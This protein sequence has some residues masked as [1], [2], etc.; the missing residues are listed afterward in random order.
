MR[1]PQKLKH[2]FLWII[3]RWRWAMA[4]CCNLLAIVQSNRGGLYRI[5]VRWLPILIDIFASFC[6]WIW[7]R[8]NLWFCGGFSHRP[9][10]IDRNKMIW[11]KFVLCI[12][13][14]SQTMFLNLKSK[15]CSRVGLN[16][17]LWNNVFETWSVLQQ[18]QWSVLGVDEFQH[19]STSICSLT[20]IRGYCSFFG[21]SFICL[22][23]FSSFFFQ[24]VCNSFQICCQFWPISF[25][26][27]LSHSLPISKAVD[28]PL[29]SHRNSNY[30]VEFYID[31]LMN[32][33]ILYRFLMVW[34][35]ESRRKSV[36][37]N[38]FVSKMIL[39]RF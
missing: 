35:W 15:R 33:M 13:R 34:R 18:Q 2:F 6:F 28:S 17:K 38:R 26:N 24:F 39:I 14:R 7:Q 22:L 11:K 23:P 5:N 19:K 12:S 20:E 31:F 36:K 27:P 16:Y 37:F 25:F 8:A 30:P 4:S 10:R 21:Y 3:K 32:R 29:K 1:K 9:R